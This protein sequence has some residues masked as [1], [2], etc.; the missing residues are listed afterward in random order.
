MSHSAGPRPGSCGAL[1]VLLES[2]G[3]PQPGPPVPCSQP[4]LFW[5]LTGAAATPG[6]WEGPEG[7]GWDR[8][9][10]GEGVL[11]PRA[12]GCW[13]GTTGEWYRPGQMSTRGQAVFPALLRADLCPPPAPGSAG[14]MKKAQRLGWGDMGAPSKWGPVPLASPSP[15]SL[16]RAFRGQQEGRRRSDEE[17]EGSQTPSWKGLLPQHAQAGAHPACASGRAPA[18][19]GG[20]ERPERPTRPLGFPVPEL[21]CGS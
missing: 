1:R 3:A 19:S 5:G 9:S 14:G 20:G 17:G 13:V 2:G 11:G 10:G 4:V 16:S 6:A 21:F 8:V 18:P 12:Q 7:G 15:A